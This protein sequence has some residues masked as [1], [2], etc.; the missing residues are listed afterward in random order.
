MDDSP[1]YMDDYMDLASGKYLPVGSSKSIDIKNESGS[2]AGAIV[3]LTALKI[4]GI[5]SKPYLETV[6][7]KYVGFIPDILDAIAEVEPFSYD[8]VTPRDGKYGSIGS[9]VDGQWSG[10]I[11]MVNSTEV[12]MV[13]A[14]LTMTSLRMEAIDFS[15]PFLTTSVTVLMK[16]NGISWKLHRGSN[17]LSATHTLPANPTTIQQLLNMT[18]TRFGWVREGSTDS[19]LSTTQHWEH[20][21][22]T[23]RF[24][25][26]GI[27]SNKEG[28]ERV[29]S[30]PGFGMVM[31][32][33]SADYEVGRDGFCQLYTVGELSQANYG[34]GFGK[35]S[36]HRDMFSRG[37][38][39]ITNNGKMFSLLKKW[40]PKN[41]NCFSSRMSSTGAV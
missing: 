31:E 35:G 12:D 30:D 28:V 41:Q 27:K 40:F 6:N 4:V 33:G 8:L 16:N 10:M 22:I 3:V 13:A 38:L 24:S 21:K 26:L 23:S 29:K 17:G 7:G 36:P 11:G 25:S 14:D 32:K 2:L 18:D 15:I 5:K 1:Y 20:Q 39:K 34:F 37:I 9:F 19:M